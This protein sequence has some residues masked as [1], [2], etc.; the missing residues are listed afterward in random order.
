MKIRLLEAYSF[1]GGE[2]TEGRTD[3]HDEVNSRIWATSSH[4]AG[5]SLA[6]TVYTNTTHKLYTFLRYTTWYGHTY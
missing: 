4:C 1:H 3:R 6:N 2:R 5:Q